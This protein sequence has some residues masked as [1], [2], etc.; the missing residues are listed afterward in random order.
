MAR[1]RFCEIIG[2]HVPHGNSDLFLMGLLSMIDVILDIPN[3]LRAGEH[4]G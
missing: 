3:G 4:S 1:A 2:D